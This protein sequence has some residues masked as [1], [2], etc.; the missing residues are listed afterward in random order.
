VARARK[1]TLV[2]LAGTAL[3]APAAALSL[4]P[5]TVFA[6]AGPARTSGTAVLEHVRVARHASFDRVVFEFRGETPAWRAAYVP[7]VVEDPS[8]KI[9]TIVG[10]SFIAVVF[11]GARIDRASAG[12]RIVLTPRFPTLLQVKKAGD[13]EGVVTFGIG[14]R[15][16][17]GFRAL[18]LSHP[19]RIVLDVT[20]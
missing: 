12:A 2:V 8:G 19:G 18:H 3:A 1:L 4:P 14:V 13:F 5:F 7:R 10:G 20:H 17:A 6:K 15:R 16:R 9:A 11:H